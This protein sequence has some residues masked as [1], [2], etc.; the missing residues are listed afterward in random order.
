MFPV[1]TFYGAWGTGT[2][3]FLKFYLKDGRIGYNKYYEV[4]GEKMDIMCEGGKSATK[5][6]KAKTARHGTVPDLACRMRGN[7]TGR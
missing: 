1:P 5:M 2:G 4:T 7:R 6:E 3:A